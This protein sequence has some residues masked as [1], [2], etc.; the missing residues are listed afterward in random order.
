M[1]SSLKKLISFL[2]NGYYGE[3]QYFYEEEKASSSRFVQTAIYELFCK[4]FTPS[5]E[6]VI[7]LTKEA[8]ERN[9][10]NGVDRNGKPVEGLD[11]TWRRIAPEA[12]IK[13]VDISSK[14]DER[15]SWEL[16]EKIFD[17]IE[18]EDEI[19]FDITHGFRS[20]PM[21]ALTV[22]NYARVLKQ[23]SLKRLLYGC[24]E[25]REEKDG[26]VFAPIID[27]TQMVSLLDWTHGVESYLK[28]GNASVIQTLTNKE[29]KSVF[30]EMR[31]SQNLALKEE[32]IALKNLA[33]QLH[34][35]SVTMQ[36]C[37]APKL[38]EEYIKL[39]KHLET[40]AN[41]EIQKFRPLGKL[42]GKME[43]KTNTFTG[44]S[45]FD[46]FVAAEWCFNNGLIQ[47][48]YTLLQEGVFSAVCRVQGIDLNNKDGRGLVSNSINIVVRKIKRDKWKV[49]KKDLDLVAEIVDFLTPY[50][51]YLISFGK[52]TEYRNSINHAGWSQDYISFQKFQPGLKQ[53][54]KELRPFFEEME[55]CYQKRR[56]E[57]L[58]EVKQ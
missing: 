25:M 40:A 1:V 27:L 15:H 36:T 21:M 37:R 24:Y 18:E 56:K 53:L 13:V 19:I 14:Q 22:L 41:I 55:A 32:S 44:C 29:V 5:D 42:L 52:L 31:E 51:K 33:D 4:D 54:L 46:D 11:S 23:A 10:I 43:E 8:K 35:F 26:A 38:Q 47:Q 34:V 2:G 20:L 3:C 7:F 17:V 28:T 9:W 39:K 16:F 48:G 50:R 45:I 57:E 58:H 6:I 12:T 30:K 49:R